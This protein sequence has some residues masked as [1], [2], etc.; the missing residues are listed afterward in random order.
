MAAS[1]SNL[2]PRPPTR[3]PETLDAAL[4]FAEAVAE[5][6]FAPHPRGQRSLSA[7]SASRVPVAANRDQQ[8]ASNHA[9]VVV[10]LE[11][12]PWPASQ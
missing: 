8:P 6:D 5:S 10:D 7:L 4:R 1:S 3:A 11:V 2:G 12:E 9:A